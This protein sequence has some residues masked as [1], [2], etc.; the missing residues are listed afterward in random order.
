MGTFIVVKQFLTPPKSAS[1]GIAVARLGCKAIGLPE[2]LPKP[3]SFAADALRKRD[4]MIAE[5]IPRNEGE[6]PEKVIHTVVIRLAA[7]SSRM[8]T[9]DGLRLV[10][11]AAIDANCRRKCGFWGD[12]L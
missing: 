6:K 12:L 5:A 1:G 10:Q 7:T 3:L 2:K 4:Q 8:Q 9:Q 11:H